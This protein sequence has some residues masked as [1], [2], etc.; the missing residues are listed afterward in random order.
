MGP[1]FGVSVL[2]QT[3]HILKKKCASFFLYVKTDLVCAVKFNV[4]FGPNQSNHNQI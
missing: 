1:F 2:N 4:K 3:L